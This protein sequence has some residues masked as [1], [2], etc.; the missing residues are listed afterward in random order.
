M[1]VRLTA[2]YYLV[3][4]VLHLGL[5]LS[6]GRQHSWVNGQQLTVETAEICLR[7]CAFVKQLCVNDIDCYAFAFGVM[8]PQCSGIHKG[9]KECNCTYK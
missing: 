6:Y 8:H 3:S 1:L 4:V 7:E 5:V 2:F 9:K